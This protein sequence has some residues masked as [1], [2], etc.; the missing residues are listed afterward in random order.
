MVDRIDVILYSHVVE[1]RSRSP[2]MA[3]LSFSQMYEDCSAAVDLCHSD[4]DI[5]S[6]IINSPGIV[7]RISAITLTLP[8]RDFHRARPRLGALP[9]AA[10]R[11]EQNDL[12]VDQQPLELH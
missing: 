7:R 3:H 6:A 12:P 1:L 8:R 5:N 9:A 2:K 10:A 4:P 11:I